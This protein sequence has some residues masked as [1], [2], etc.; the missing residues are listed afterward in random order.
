MTDFASMHLELAEPDLEPDYEW[1]REVLAEDGDPMAELIQ[2]PKRPEAE[3]REDLR[4]AVSFIL[5]LAGKAGQQDTIMRLADA[6]AL[7]VAAA[8]LGGAFA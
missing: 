6:Y 3:A 7:A 2:L 1:R 5:G 4:G 8:E